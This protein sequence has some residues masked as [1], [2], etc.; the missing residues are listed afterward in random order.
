MLAPII[1]LGP[2]TAALADGGNAASWPPGGATPR[3]A[4]RAG[5]GNALPNLLS[6]DVFDS[7]EALRCNFVQRVAPR[8]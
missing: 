7:A 3:M 6:A 5:V 8:P 2:T 4:E 1:V